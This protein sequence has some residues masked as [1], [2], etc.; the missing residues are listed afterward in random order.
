MGCIVNW[1]SKNPPPLQTV[2]LAANGC[3]IN[4]LKADADMA[5]A[6]A[7]G[8]IID[9]DAQT[10][11]AAELTQAK[12][13]CIIDWDAKTDLTALSATAPSANGCIVNWMGVSEGDLRN[14]VQGGCI[15]NW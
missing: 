6:N 5:S 11:I 8:C 15:I 10:D 1:D 2:P 4:W 13:G 9:W 7:T 12:G 3:I 14:A